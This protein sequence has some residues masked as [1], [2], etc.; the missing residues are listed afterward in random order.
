MPGHA[1]ANRDY[2]LIGRKATLRRSY[3]ELQTDLLRA[4]G[5][6]GSLAQDNREQAAS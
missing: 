3:S 6:T 1:A 5:R 2:V 4:L